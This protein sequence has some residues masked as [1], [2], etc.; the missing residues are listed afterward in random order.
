MTAGLRFS[1]AGASASW[2]SSA[3]SPGRTS[4]SPASRP[5]PSANGRGITA[6]EQRPHLCVVLVVGVD[7]LDVLDRDPVSPRSPARFPCRCRGPSWSRRVP[8][9]SPSA[10]VGW[11]RRHRP[12]PRGRHRCRAAGGERG[13]PAADHGQDRQ[14]PRPS[15]IALCGPT[16]RVPVLVRQ[17]RKPGLESGAGSRLLDVEDRAPP[18]AQSRPSSIARTSAPRVGLRERDGGEDV[19]S[20][21]SQ[22]A[23]HRADVLELGRR[24]A[25]SM[26]VY[27]ATVR[28]RS[29]SSW[30]SSSAVNSSTSRR[31]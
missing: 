27:M 21:P 2:S 20:A 11:T 17:A 8:L 10:S 18:A 16:S 12:H 14:Q 28:Q 4:A 6:G 9:A 3:D 24:L 19:G 13:P 29:S 1:N 7:V 22:A 31:R 26:M 25:S 23:L 30:G 5:R 15:S